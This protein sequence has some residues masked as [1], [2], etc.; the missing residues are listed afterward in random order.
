[1]QELRI[2]VNRKGDIY[3]V[4]MGGEPYQVFRIP[5]EC[6]VYIYSQIEKL[7]FATTK[8]YFNGVRFNCAAQP[9]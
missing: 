1:M 9:G 8:V 6:L 5:K 7:D 3:T 2:E 4:C